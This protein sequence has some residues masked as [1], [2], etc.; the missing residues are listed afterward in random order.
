MFPDLVERFLCLRRDFLGPTEAMVNHP[1]LSNNDGKSYYAPTY[2]ETLGQ[3]SVKSNRCYS[4]SMTHQCPRSLVG[5]M[6]GGKVYDEEE[7][8]KNT[9]LR[10]RVLEVR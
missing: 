1:G 6:A 7:M 2:F 3:N 8:D 5:P 10:K 9:T 4:A